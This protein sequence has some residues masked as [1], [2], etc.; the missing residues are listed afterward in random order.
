MARD[1]STDVTTQKDAVQCRPI[2]L[3]DFYLGSQSAVDANTHFFT[4]YIENISFFDLEENA[5]TYLPIAGK[6]TPIKTSMDMAVDQFNI[7]LD[8]VDIT[9]LIAMVAG[10]DFR[11]RRLVIRKV[12]LDEL[13]EAADA[14]I[15][16]DGKINRV[17][18]TEKQFNIQVISKINLKIKTG[19]FF[20]QLCPWTFGGAYCGFSRDTDKVSAQTCD[21]G[22]TTTTIKDAARSEEDNYWKH[23][24][25]EFTSGA[26]D[27][28]KRRVTAS[29][30]SGTTLTLDIALNN[31]PSPG[32]TY[33]L[34]RGCDKTL[35][36]C[37]N[38][39]ANDANFGGFHTIP[40]ELG[41]EQ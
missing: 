3:Y 41:P 35:D 32:D 10:I 5:Q 2:E 13:D 29:N 9:D 19:R 30:Q 7:T 28:V 34:Y 21:V 26:N 36:W 24:Q 39:L 25:I 8:A 15:I 27:G 38:K 22:C 33:T 6:R 12:F 37:E 4:S 23:G 14:V 20:Q 16:F 17:T 11:D 18:I 40:V 31:A 1:L